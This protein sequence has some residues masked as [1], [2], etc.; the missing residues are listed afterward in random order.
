MVAEIIAWS[1]LMSRWTCYEKRD[2]V[3]GEP[4]TPMLTS[5]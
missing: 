2:R 5:R 1:L 4:G 3:K